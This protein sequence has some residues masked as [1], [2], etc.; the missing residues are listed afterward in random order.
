MPRPASI[1]KRSRLTLELDVPVRERLETLRALTHAANVTEVIRRALAL[2]DTIVALG[3]DREVRLVVKDK[4]GN[5]ESLL[6]PTRAI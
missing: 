6:L 1:Q 2:Y 5:V 3:E 4:D